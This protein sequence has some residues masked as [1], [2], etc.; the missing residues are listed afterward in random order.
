MVK[1]LGNGKTG[2]VAPP[3][4]T[5]VNR[6]LCDGGLLP[7]EVLIG[8]MRWF[9]TESVD[10]WKDAQKEGLDPAEKA[11]LHKRAVLLRL[12]AIMCAKESAPY[13]HP[14]LA[15]ISIENSGGQVPVVLQIDAVDS[16][17]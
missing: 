9:V 4:R 10:A 3:S 7:I 1:S 15:S 14:R 12:D 11:A 2:S 16:G 8:S 6:L 17:L 5:V 13:M